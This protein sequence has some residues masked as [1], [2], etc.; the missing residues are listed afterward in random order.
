[1]NIIQISL[2]FSILRRTSLCVCVCVN[3]DKKRHRCKNKSAAAAAAN[4]YKY[5]FQFSLNANKTVPSIYWF[6]ANKME[7]QQ[8]RWRWRRR[9]QRELWT[10]E[11]NTYRQRENNK[12]F[13]SS[14]PKSKTAG[15]E[16]FSLSPKNEQCC[17]KLSESYQ[18]RQK[19][20]ASKRG[21]KKKGA[22]K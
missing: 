14:F 20:K 16:M 7:Q 12:K 19:A 1:M 6:I 11:R 5:I 13:R 3:G 22:A 4:I 9:W 18:V 8:W 17:E 21:R 15:I 2:T 10:R